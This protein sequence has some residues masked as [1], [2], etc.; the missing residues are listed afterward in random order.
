[1]RHNIH[2]IKITII[3]KRILNKQKVFTLLTLSTYVCGEKQ[4]R[5][6]L[7][8]MM[9]FIYIIFIFFFFI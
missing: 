3:I 9:F 2:H 4:F 8:Q 6:K 7:K 5:I 1:M